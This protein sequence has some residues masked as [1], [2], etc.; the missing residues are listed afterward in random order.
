MKIFANNYAIKG[1]GGHVKEYE[2]SEELHDLATDHHNRFIVFLTPN[3]LEQNQKLLKEKISISAGDISVIDSLLT[4]TNPTCGNPN[5]SWIK[6]EVIIPALGEG[7]SEQTVLIYRYERMPN[8]RIIVSSDLM[9]ELFS[10]HDKWHEQGKDISHVY[11]N[12]L[13]AILDHFDG[14]LQKLKEM[15]SE[16]LSEIIEKKR[17]ISKIKTKFASLS[18]EEFFSKE[19]AHDSRFDRTKEALH[20][21][22]EEANSEAEYYESKSTV[23]A[24]LSAS[25]P[26]KNLSDIAKA[27]GTSK[28]E[29]VFDPYLDNKGL[30]T[31][32]DILSLGASMSDSVRMLSSRGKSGLTGT[33]VSAWFKQHRIPNGE[34]RIMPKSEHR[35]FLTLDSGEVLIIGASFNSLDK[36]EV[37]SMETDSSQD[38]SFFDSIWQKASVL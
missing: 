24:R 13:D 14:I 15:R 5:C 25:T 37:I 6:E 22:E 20:L 29:I 2:L 9:P 10:I 30:G 11:E 38:L 27:I 35:R 12:F 19:G 32:G 26:A 31:L 28:I 34:I 3:E 18:F 21:I 8:G 4:N 23:S 36:N 16:N 1:L 17:Q 7:H 33:Y